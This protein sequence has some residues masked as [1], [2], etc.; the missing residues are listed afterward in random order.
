M[1]TDLNT[2]KTEIERLEANSINVINEIERSTEFDKKRADMARGKAIA[3]SH[4]LTL[5]RQILR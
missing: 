3:Y 5:I 2:L 1:K 4:V